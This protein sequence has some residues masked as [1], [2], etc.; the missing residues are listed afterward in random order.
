MVSEVEV[1]SAA[2][3]VQSGPISNVRCVSGICLF[4]R[5]CLSVCL[6]VRLAVCL[7]DIE[8][9]TQQRPPP[10]SPLEK[11]PPVGSFV[12]SVPPLQL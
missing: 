11:E 8:M 4:V 5:V 6:L 10:P 2:D 7:S 12:P 9:S 3:P 1:V